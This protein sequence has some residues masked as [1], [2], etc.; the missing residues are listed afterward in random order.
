MNQQDIGF[1]ANEY[2]SL[3]H[4]V[5]A[6]AGGHLT[7]TFRPGGK[8]E[9]FATGFGDPPPRTIKID[10]FEPSTEH[11]G[12]DKRYAI[13]N[14]ASY[15]LVA[16]VYRA[17]DAYG[18]EVSA[19]ALNLDLSDDGRQK[20]ILAATLAALTTIAGH[21]VAL[22]TI[23]T[24]L[25]TRHATLYAVPG[26]D[27]A[28]A[29][30]DVEA[31][32]VFRGMDVS[33]KEV[34]ARTADEPANERMMLALLRSPVRLTDALQTHVDNAWVRSVTRQKPVQTA[35]LAI[36]EEANDWARRITQFIAE[37]LA[38]PNTNGL[39]GALSR[40][41]LYK[42]LRASRATTLIK[43]EDHERDLFER[44]IFNIEKTNA[45][46]AA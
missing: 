25:A 10:R 42:H 19:A 32:T 4:M 14:N 44:D 6:E 21:F 18:A 37:H 22:E 13:T 45:T 39:A 5:I 29:A 1:N 20:R 2:H 26:V 30:V 31:R 23:R 28:I 15:L 41:A 27:A 38:H 9:G 16:R 40:I 33:T 12:P 8:V 43:F 35:Q 3:K 7:I 36:E 46:A 11:E 34:L 24:D 17:A